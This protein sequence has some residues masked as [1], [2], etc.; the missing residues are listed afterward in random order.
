M[1]TASTDLRVMPVR[2]A[3]VLLAMASA[4]SSPRRQPAPLPAEPTGPSTAPQGRGASA[5]ANLD[6]AFADATQAD[7]ALLPDAAVVV[8]D[9]TYGE[10]CKLGWRSK[11]QSPRKKTVTCGVG[12]SCCYPCGVDGCDFTCLTN[13]ECS[14]PRP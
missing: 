4:C 2:A 10:V 13:A 6:A 3:A 9:K 8:R 14:V 11:E 5:D 1:T 7:A 12:L